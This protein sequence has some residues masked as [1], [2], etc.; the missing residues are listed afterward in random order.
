MP[1]SLETVHE[2]ENQEP[3]CQI[4]LCKVFATR[5][6]TGIS[7]WSQDLSSKS[8]LWD[9]AESLYRVLNKGKVNS[10]WDPVYCDKLLNIPEFGW[11]DIQEIQ[12]NLKCLE[13]AGYLPC[14]RQGA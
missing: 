4:R 1:L 5:H 12:F 8:P 11:E 14:A 9:Y 6:K 3:S 10:K 2:A 7:Y 13:N